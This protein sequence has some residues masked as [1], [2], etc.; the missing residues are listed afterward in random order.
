[1]MLNIQLTLLFAVGSW[2]FVHTR[3]FLLHPCATVVVEYYSRKL[4]YLLCAAIR[5][6]V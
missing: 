1:M 4:C 3:Y 2:F 6:A 5:S